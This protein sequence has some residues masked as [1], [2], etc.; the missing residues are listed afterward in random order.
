M[1]SK[2]ESL[3]ELSVNRSQGD[4]DCW[5]PAGSGHTRGHEIPFQP[6]MALRRPFGA[7]HSENPL[8]GDLGQVGLR[9]GIYLAR[10]PWAWRLEMSRSANS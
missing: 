1:P 4:W 5:G 9:K 2:V 10:Q 7:S 8:Q 6:W 3:P